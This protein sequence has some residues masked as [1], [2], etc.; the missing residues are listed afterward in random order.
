MLFC[1]LWSHIW[2]IDDEAPDGE[3]FA[4]YEGHVFYAVSFG[5]GEGGLG[6]GAAAYCFWSGEVGGGKGGGRRGE[7][8]TNS[9]SLV[10]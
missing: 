7:G 2:V 9:A 4:D 8:Q 3:A 5:G 6:D 1:V 10:H